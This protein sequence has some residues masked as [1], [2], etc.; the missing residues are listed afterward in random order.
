MTG[1]RVWE[2]VVEVA[3]RDDVPWFEAAV[4]GF[5][6]GVASFEN[7]ATGIWRITGYASAEPDAAALAAKVQA[8][9]DEAGRPPPAVRTGLMADTD[10]VAEVEKGLRP[11]RVGPYYVYGSHVR[12]PPPADAIPL[13]VDAGLAFGTG[14]HET[15]R[16]CLIALERLFPE[17]GPAR[18]FDVGTGSGI[19][20][21]AL[22]RRYGVAVLGSDIDPIA[23]RVAAENAHI[24]GVAELTE[25]V[26]C[27]GLD[28]ARIAD[29]RPYDLIVANIVENPLIA[30]A[31][32]IAPALTEDG[33]G[34]LSGILAGQVR[35][36]ADAYAAVG[37]AVVDEVPLNDWRTLILRRQ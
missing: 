31:P 11:I 37:L 9:A 7:G 2:I 15:T 30:L 33:V 6:D 10:W 1:D 32:S 28:H 4:A 19:L 12:E 16:G 17:R 5:A 24:N 27:P 20:A 18:P 3:A 21:I 29:G 36:V 14:S 25:F 26:A 34:V 22:A 8:A 23:V 35:A 13:R